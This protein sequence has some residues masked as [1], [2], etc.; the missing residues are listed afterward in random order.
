MLK[1]KIIKELLIVLN[2]TNDLGFKYP[3]GNKELTIQVRALEMEGSI[4]YDALK[5]K[6]TTKGVK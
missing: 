6:W 4:S 5:A 1:A 2:S 3:I